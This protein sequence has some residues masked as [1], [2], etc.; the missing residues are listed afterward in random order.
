[1]NVAGGLSTG[2]DIWNLAVLPYLLGNSECWVE[3][4][5]KAMNILNS[6]QNDFFRC[7]FSTP[8][9]TPISAFY[10]DTGSLLIE[11]HII[12]RKLN[13]LYHLVTLPDSSLAKKI[14]TIQKENALPGLV[15]EC[16]EHLIILGIFGDPALYTKYQWKK[17]IKNKVHAKNKSDLLI[18]IKD[19]KKLE[20]EK[21]ISEEYGMKAYINAMTVTRARMFF[22]IR[23][24]MVRTVQYNYR[25]KPEYRENNYLCR[26]GEEDRQSHL[27]G[28]CDVYSFCTEGLDL[29]VPAD[30][31]TL[32][33]RIIN[34]REKEEGNRK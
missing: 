19:Y 21:I 14:Y 30:L 9:G 32:F 15:K 24:Q 31:V 8:T 2:L 34:E 12:Q 18:Q 6:I 10:W 5:K 11:N 3:I 22:A 7:L 27:L 17:L 33:Q 20:Y 28:H 4:P 23:T 1:M 16:E 25:N 13:F 29:S 26:C